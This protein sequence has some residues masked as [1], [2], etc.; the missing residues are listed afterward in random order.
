MYRLDGRLKKFPYTLAHLV[1]PIPGSVGVMVGGHT[2]DDNSGTGSNSEASATR[3]SANSK[4]RPTATR[5]GQRNT[6]QRRAVVEIMSENPHFRTAADIHRML[7]ERGEK[8]GLTTVYRTL[9]SLAELDVVDMLHNS[10]GE[11]YYRLC[12]DHHHHHLV[13]TNCGETV[14]VTGGPVEQWARDLAQ[15]HGFSMT[16]HSAEVFGLCGNCQHKA[17]AK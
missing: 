15:E 13:C 11:A 1:Q 7:T 16:G 14:E 12:G 4:T 9:Q 6:R 3:S 10:S 5:I 17:D 8:V 2:H